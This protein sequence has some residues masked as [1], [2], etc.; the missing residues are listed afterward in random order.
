MRIEKDENQVQSPVI[1]LT[2]DIN[3]LF[4]PSM[5]IAISPSASS[6]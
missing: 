1:G 2:T 5:G 3:T 6:C 4:R